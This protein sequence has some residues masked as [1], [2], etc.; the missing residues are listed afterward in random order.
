M[1]RFLLLP[2]QFLASD[3]F[4]FQVYPASHQYYLTIIVNY[5]WESVAMAHGIADFRTTVED[6]VLI[7]AGQLTS[8]AATHCEQ[9]RTMLD[10]RS[11]LIGMVFTLLFN[12]IKGCCIITGVRIRSIAKSPIF[13]G[14]Q[15]RRNFWSLPL[16]LIHNINVVIVV[17]QTKNHMFMQTFTSG[18]RS[19]HK[20]GN[21]C[22]SGYG[23]ITQCLMP[24]FP[25][26]S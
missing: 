20:S 23:F 10:S 8:Q 12:K 11:K 6:W 14:K 21:C 9:N 18:V 1:T 2:F 25:G 16:T 24:L 19:V 17:S 15:T 5:I 7:T 22:A 4:D 26:S 13:A 3:P